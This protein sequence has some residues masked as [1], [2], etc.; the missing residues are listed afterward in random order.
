MFLSPR[1][2][3]CATLSTVRVLVCSGNAVGIPELRWYACQ[4][5]KGRYGTDAMQLGSGVVT[6]HVLFQFDGTVDTAGLPALLAV[7]VGYKPSICGASC[8]WPSG[9]L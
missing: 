4:L 8:V 1:R 9:S 5:V 7:L 3:L 6:A 2:V